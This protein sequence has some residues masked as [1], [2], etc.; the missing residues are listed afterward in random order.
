MAE[1]EQSVSPPPKTVGFLH[2]LFCILFPDDCRLCGEPLTEFTRVPVC[3]ACLD[4][5][6]PL[7][8]EAAVCDGCGIPRDAAIGTRCERCAAGEYH[9]AQA[10]SF[11]V[12]DGALREVLH[13]FKYQGLQPLAAPLAERM[14]RV[15]QAERWDQAGFAGVLAVPLSPARQRQRG[16]NQ[17][18]LLAGEFSKLTGIPLVKDACRRARETALQTGLTR[19]QRA[20]NMRG[21][22]APGPRAHALRDRAILL[23]D[24][25]L[26]TGATLSACARAVR[27][28]GAARVCALTVARTLH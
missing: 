11:G 19:A 12:Y 9:F 13:L 18:E 17:A 25:V 21:A 27:Q 8:A 16:Y 1:A 15:F 6:R 10:R 26:T 14:S 4:G 7:R 2:T 23:I 5:L 24:D 20:E 3:R 28:A 22:F